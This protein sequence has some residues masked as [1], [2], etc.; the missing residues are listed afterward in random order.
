MIKIH[1]CIVSMLLI[2]A[3]SGIAEASG[4]DLQTIF[5]DDFND[6][7]YDGWNIET[8]CFFAQNG[9]LE[10]RCTAVYNV[11]SSTITGYSNYSDVLN[12]SFDWRLNSADSNCQAILVQLKNSSGDV[13][14]S[15]GGD[16][17]YPWNGKNTYSIKLVL[18]GNPQGDFEYVPWTKDTNWHNLRVTLDNGK[19]TVYHDGVPVIVTDGPEQI[20][21]SGLLVHGW[22]HSGQ[23]GSAW[24]NIKVEL[25]DKVPPATNIELSGTLGNNG[26]YTSDVQAN[27][28]AADNERGSGIN[29]TEYSFDDINWILYT[30]P[31]TIT[32]EGTT[33]IYYRSIDNAGNTESTKTQTVK[34]DKT[35]PNIDGAPITSPNANGWYNTDV[36]VHFTSSDAISGVGSVTPDT[37]LSAEGV[38]LFAI[39]TATDMAGNSNS[40]AVSG[41]N[42][43][44]TPPQVTINTPAS[45]GM[46]LLNQALSADWSASDSL[47]GLTSAKGTL[48]GGTAIDTST[49]GSKTFT[50]TATDYAANTAIQTSHYTIAYNF[51]GILPPIKTDGSSIFKLG[52]TVPVKFRIADANGNYV[53]TA[54]ANLTY[55]KITD[56]IL[57][58]IEEPVSTSAANEGN[59]FRYDSTD[60]L[61]IFNLGTN[62]MTAGTYQLNINLDDGTVHTVRISLR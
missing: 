43:D 15:T 61:Y 27:L 38:N 59:T 40:A 13:F 6:G 32:N 4:S 45:G 57:G 62:G 9:Y 56:D 54:V 23:A 14:L 7:N 46:Y 5:F 17:C 2:L 44:K 21:V 20:D 53:S 58:N 47:S 16:Y 48:P 3:F 52:S 24:D 41:I 36:I 33:T 8:G 22:T 55:Q 39:G 49:V 35:P 42:V 34:I 26:W 37:T 18:L 30:A 28:T 31:F 51:L 19:Y 29:K 10:K 1:K 12:L 25:A 60:N 11:A 50:V